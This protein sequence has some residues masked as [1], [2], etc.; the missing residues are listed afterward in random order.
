MGMSFEEV[1]M[2]DT[3]LVQNFLRG[4]DF[5]EGTRALLIDKDSKPQWQPTQLRD[6]STDAV[7]S[8]FH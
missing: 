6:V 7:L 3:V 4:H 1:M 5:F 8:Y 2:Q